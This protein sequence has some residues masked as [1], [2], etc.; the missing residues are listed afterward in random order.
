MGLGGNGL[1]VTT[2][3][4]NTELHGAGQP[5]SAGWGRRRR[6]AHRSAC[7]SAAESR[8]ARLEPQ[9][10]PGVEIVWNQRDNVV[11][12]GAGQRG[13]QPGRGH[14]PEISGWHRRL[15]EHSGVADQLLAGQHGVLATG[16][17]GHGGGDGERGS[18]SVSA[19]RRGP[20]VVLR[21]ALRHAFLRRLHQERVSNGARAATGDHHEPECRPRRI[22]RRVRVPANPHRPI[23]AGDYGFRAAIPCGARV[24]RC[25]IRRTRT[26][27]R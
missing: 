23:H 20:M 4:G 2:D 22:P 17:P 14:R 27:H 21:R 11:Q 10:L 15:A 16:L 19:I 6:L 13:R 26:I 25:S 7:H 18:D 9:L 12:Y 1:T 3:T 24:S 8:R 5:G